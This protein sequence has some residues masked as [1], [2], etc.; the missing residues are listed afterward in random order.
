MLY[1]LDSVVAVITPEM[2][3]HC[4]RWAGN[5]TDWQNNVQTLRNF[6]TNRCN[7]M[8]SGFMNCYSLTGPYNITLNLD[9]PNSGTL[10]LNTLHFTSAQLPWH[11]TYFGNITTSLTATPEPNYAFANWTTQSQVLNPNL[12]TAAVTAN[13]NTADSIVAHFSLVT[14]IGEYPG[15]EVNAS[16]YPTAFSDETTLEYTL[17]KHLPVTLKMTN[18]LGDEVSTINSP[19]KCQDRGAYSVKLNLANSG[20]AGGIYLLNFIAGDYHKT[21]KLVYSPK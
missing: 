5:I 18:L 14:T 21:I 7:Y 17:P 12:T 13:I 4:T 1:K 6:I 3:R 8:S 20:L 2:P 10:D 15:I 11:G 9:P 16:A 19:T